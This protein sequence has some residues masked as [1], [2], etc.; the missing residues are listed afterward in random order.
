MVLI[1]PARI[2]R[3]TTS[4]A[5]SVSVPVGHGNPLNDVDENSFVPQRGAHDPCETNFAA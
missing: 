2:P 5:V 4:K 3:A 1:D